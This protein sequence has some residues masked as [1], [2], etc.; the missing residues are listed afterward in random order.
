MRASEVQFYEVPTRQQLP[1]ELTVGSV[2][3]LMDSGTMMINHGGGKIIEYGGGR[4]GEGLEEDGFW[5]VDQGGTGSKTPEGAR[6][7]LGALGMADN[8]AS[9]SRLQTARNITLF[10]DVD[11]SA[12]F[13]GQNDIIINTEVSAG[14]ALERTMYKINEVRGPNFASA[15]NYPTESAVRNELDK[16]ANATDVLPNYKGVYVN[17]SALMSA[18]P[19]ARAGDTAVVTETNTTWA[20]SSAA[21]VGWFDTG[22]IIQMGI[23][24]VNGKQGDAIT[25]DLVTDL[26]GMTRT[27]IIDAIEFTDLEHEA[28]L[29][30]SVREGL[31]ARQDAV[32]TD[33]PFALKG[34]VPQIPEEITGLPVRVTAAEEKITSLETGQGTARMITTSILLSRELDGLTNVPV[35][36]VGEQT[37]PFGVSRTMVKDTAGSLGVVMDVTPETLVVQTVTTSPVGDEHPVYLGMVQNITDLP[38]TQEAAYAVFNR[39]PN[40]AD[41]CRVITDET[42]QGSSVE[43]RLTDNL[44]DNLTWGSPFV[45]NTTLYQAQTTADMAG[46]FLVA[47]ETPGTWGP[48]FDIT[49]LYQ[50]WQMD[51][52]LGD[53]ALAA[54]GS[55]LGSLMKDIGVW[56]GR[57]GEELVILGCACLW[58]GGTV[59]ELAANPRVRLMY[60]HRGVGGWVE[61]TQDIN[62]ER[63]RSWL[64][65]TV[66]PTPL[67]ITDSALFEIHNPTAVAGL[68]GLRL[69]VYGYLVPPK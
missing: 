54:T 56:A 39:R 11:G 7:A 59:S 41:Y 49:R 3:W 23:Q 29:P 24:S 36:T 69:S 27:E 53:N 10:G 18:W 67:R 60:Q 48:A 8:A 17:A 14:G 31:Y 51:L 16:K 22:K 50:R 25:L 35:S 65:N 30:T 26:G 1:P 32:S 44:D 6:M 63:R 61:H 57:T 9:A 34:D 37:L 4:G 47:G 66:F 38:A 12:Y 40:L 52:Y 45:I 62:I 13:D 68:G 5:R 46:R 2:Y 15:T 64:L 19:A 55:R 43:Y 21:P 58:R 42:H 33:N 28:T 20:W